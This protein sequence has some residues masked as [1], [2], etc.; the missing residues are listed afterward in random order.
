MTTI[1]SIHDDYDRTNDTPDYQPVVVTGDDFDRLEEIAVRIHPCRPPD[2]IHGRSL[3]R[4]NTGDD[5]P[6]AVTEAAWLARGLDPHIEA[7]RI[8][9]AIFEEHL[10]GDAA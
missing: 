2:L 7:H 6:C 9:N 3:C 10:G 4:C 5:W 8:I 1:R